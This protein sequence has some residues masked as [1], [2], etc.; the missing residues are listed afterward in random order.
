MQSAPLRALI[1]AA[2]IVST[3]SPTLAAAQP[4]EVQRANGVA[5]ISGGVG[6]ESMSTLTRMENQFNLKLFLVGQSGSY[7][8][9][10]SITITDAQGKGVLLTTSEG[11]VLLANLPG[12]TYLV[13]A[14]K[15]GQT[16]EQR[17]SVTSGKL[18]TTYFRFPGE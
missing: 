14:Q 9:N 13:K 17:V 4:P 3:L 1:S 7:L 11:P 18:Q 10:I 16:L 8:S 6:D 12:G 2:L 15:N 5:F